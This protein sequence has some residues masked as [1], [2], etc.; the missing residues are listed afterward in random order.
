MR[1]RPPDPD[2]DP[3][4]GAPATPAPADP[5]RTAIDTAESDRRPYRIWT[6]LTTDDPYDCLAY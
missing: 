1:I 4:R 5:T 6:S 2:P 3:D